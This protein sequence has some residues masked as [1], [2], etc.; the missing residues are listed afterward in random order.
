LGVTKEFAMSW[1]R[2]RRAKKSVSFNP[3]HNYVKS[4]V[5]DYIKNGGTIK[6]IEI[7]EDAYKAFVKMRDAAADDFLKG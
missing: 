4:A 1:R 6:K 3:N 7:D 5:E 2:G